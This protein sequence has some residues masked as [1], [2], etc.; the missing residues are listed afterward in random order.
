MITVLH[1]GTPLDGGIVLSDAQRLEGKKGPGGELPVITNTTTQHQ[2]YGVVL[3][4]NNRLKHLHIQDT[5]N[6]GIV[7]SF[8]LQ[9]IGGEL[10][11]QSILVTGA[12]QSAQIIGPGPFFAPSIGLA[13]AADIDITIKNSEVGEA[14]VSSIGISQ[15][16]GHADV[17]INNTVVRDQG[18]VSEDFQDVSPGIAISATNSSSVDLAIIDSTVHNIGGDVNS[19]SDGLLLLNQGSGAMNVIVDGYRYSNPDEGGY[20]GS[21]TGIEMG[22]FQ[23]SGG[24]SFNGV[25]TNS[26]IEDAYRA[27]IQVLDQ[28]SGGGNALIAEVRDNQISGT[29]DGIQ[30]FTDATPFS[31]M[32][33]DI[34]GN[35]IATANRFGCNCSFGI[36]ATVG[37]GSTNVFDVRIEANTVLNTPGVGLLFGRSGS[38]NSV[39]L[40]AGL[41]GL[42]SAGQNRIIGTVGVDILSDGMPVSAADNWWGSASGPLVVEELNGGTVDVDPFLTTDPD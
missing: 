2:G 8:S 21:S 13:S 40:D 24:G 20:S 6:S 17:H 41:G 23:S 36:S 14:N 16:N 10:L 37:S 30:V 42:G 3:A 1:S 31:N 27:G 33:V 26:V 35:T 34:S 28:I 29:W 9:P 12:N 15:V 19:N 39:Q 5:Q 22:F 25:V 38:V 11:I 7:G 4:R 32:S 18:E